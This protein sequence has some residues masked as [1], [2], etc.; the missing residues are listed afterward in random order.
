MS[1]RQGPFLPFLT[2]QIKVCFYSDMVDLPSK[3]LSSCSKANTL[4]LV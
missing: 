4:V 1:L 2:F 3:R